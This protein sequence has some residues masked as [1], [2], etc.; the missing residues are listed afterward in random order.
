M[1]EIVAQTVRGAEQDIGISEDAGH[2]QLVLILEIAAVTPFEHQNGDRVFTVDSVIG[3]VK[4]GNRMGN[5]TVA[6]EFAVDIQI[7]AGIHALE[8]KHGAYTRLRMQF[9]SALIQCARIVDRNERRI[10]RE[11]IAHIG[12]LM[13]V[14]AVRLPYA[15]NGNRRVEIGFGCEFVRK[16]LVALEIVERPFAVQ[17]HKALGLRAIAVHRTIAMRKRDEIRVRRHCANVQ[18]VGILMEMQLFHEP[19]FP[20]CIWCLFPLYRIR[21]V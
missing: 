6:D 4:F 11:R 8:A 19:F 7:E 10:I 21:R 16:L 9:D 14:V 17:I 18:N 20:F 5:L 2:A 1:N 3:Q 15:R 12:V 13:R